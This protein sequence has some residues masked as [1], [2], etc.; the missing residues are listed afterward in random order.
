MREGDRVIVL[1]GRYAGLCGKVASVH[2]AAVGVS[3]DKPPPGLIGPAIVDSNQLAV[4]THGFA[5]FRR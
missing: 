5:D 3:L 2:R 1:K 4:T